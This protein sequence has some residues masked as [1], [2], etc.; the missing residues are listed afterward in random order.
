MFGF[1]KKTKRRVSRLGP[2]AWVVTAPR[3]RQAFIKYLHQLL[4]SGSC[5]FIEG[6]VARD[7]KHFLRER[8]PTDVPNVPTDT[9]WPRPQTFHLPVTQKNTEGLA[10]LMKQHALPEV[11][12][13][14]KAYV[15]ETMLLEWHDVYCDDPLFLSLVINEV[16]IKAFCE[17]L[18]CEFERKVID[19]K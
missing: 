14:L 16:V 19:Q 4:P 10:R 5:L 6:T 1:R 3:N 18:G 8:Q 7:V 9:L 12:D 15:G 17:H 13:H 2:E 11:L